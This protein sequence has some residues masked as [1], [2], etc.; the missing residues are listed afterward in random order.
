MKVKKQP[1]HLYG[2]SIVHTYTTVCGLQLLGTYKDTLDKK[3][4]TCKRCLRVMG[5]QK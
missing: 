5:K 3:K 4:V 2:A 1:V